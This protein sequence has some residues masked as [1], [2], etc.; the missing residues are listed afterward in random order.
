MKKQ[1]LAA[2]TMLIAF[3]SIM[4]V[5]AQVTPPITSGAQLTTGVGSGLHEVITAPAN[6]WYVIFPSTSGKPSSSNCA[7]SN[8]SPSDWTATAF[9]MGQMANGQNQYFDTDSAVWASLA[10]VGT[11]RNYVSFGGPLV[12]NLVCYYETTSAGSNVVLAVFQSS[13]GNDQFVA[14]SLA[15]PVLEG[16]AGDFNGVPLQIAASS[17]GTSGKDLF[18]LEGFKD[19]STGN[20]FV[21]TYGFTFYGTFAAGIYLKFIN[22]QASS[23]TLTNSLYIVEWSGTAGALPAAGDT[24]TI[25]Y[26]GTS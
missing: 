13:G 22:S 1:L 4:F 9:L 8:A 2:I 15:H 23:I 6:S 5:S 26:T 14:N 10:P 17:A 12:N 7:P 19:P 20:V 21:V 25:V 24:Y 16:T 11:S 3:G 18:L